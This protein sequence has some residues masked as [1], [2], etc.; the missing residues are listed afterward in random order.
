MM[1]STTKRKCVKEAKT[2]PH[3]EED[4]EKKAGLQNPD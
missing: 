1:Q 2:K 4:A 3:T